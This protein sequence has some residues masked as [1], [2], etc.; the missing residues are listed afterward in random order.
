MCFSR[1][2][3]STKEA[4]FSVGLQGIAEEDTERVKLLISQTI[5]DIIEY[6]P[7]LMPTL[8]MLTFLMNNGVPVSQL[9]RNQPLS[10]MCCH[11]NGFEEEQ[12]E[13]LLHKIEI[14]MKHQSTNFGLSLASVSSSDL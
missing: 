2:D 14:Q 12:I 8:L 7:S 9:S 5:D 10:A 4:S 1:Y 11:R 3:G 13:A 6:A